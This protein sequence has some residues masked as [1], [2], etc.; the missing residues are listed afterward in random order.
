MFRPIVYVLTGSL[1]LVCAGGCAFPTSIGSYL[2]NRRQDLID[3]AHVDVSAVNFGAAVYAGPFL[4]G[5]DY[6][7]GLGAR[8]QSSTLQIGLGGPRVVG[9]RGVAAGLIVPASHW[10]GDRATT[11]ER[12]KR[13]PSGVSV[14]ASAGALVGAG[15]EVDVLE[16]IDFALGIACIDV[17]GDDRD[18]TRPSTKPIEDLAVRAAGIAIDRAIGV[19][20]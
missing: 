5:I 17:S 4:V 15:V 13:T 3:V 10:N 20:R 18:V 11:G 7:G 2:E 19:P 9:R 8:G 16:L 1:A 12:P 6:V 14:G